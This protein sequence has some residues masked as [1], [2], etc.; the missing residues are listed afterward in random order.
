MV[1][2]GK[3]IES[4]IF[5]GYDF[6]GQMKCQRNELHERKDTDWSGGAYPVQMKLRC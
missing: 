2:G 6:E 1:L 4:R 5:G 3:D